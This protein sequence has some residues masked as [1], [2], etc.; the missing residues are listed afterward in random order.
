MTIKFKR[1]ILLLNPPAPR[2]YLR[3][4][5]C[6]KLSSGA[7]Y[8]QPSDLTV[9]SGVLNKSFYIYVI[10]AIAENKK[11]P[12]ILK[13]IARKKIKTIISLIGTAT[14]QEDLSTLKTLKEKHQ[15]FIAVSGDIVLGDTKEIFQKWPFIDAL[16]TDFTSCEINSFFKST[17]RS[18][19]RYFGINYRNNS[20]KLIIGPEKPN[21]GLISLPL[22]R[23]DL[24]PL[25]RYRLPFFDNQG[26]AT[27]SSSFGCPFNCD[28]C[29]LGTQTYR[30]RSPESIV[31]EIEMIFSLGI[32]QFIFRDPLFEANLK[33]AK[34]ICHGIISH[35]LK[36]NWSCNSRVDTILKDLNLLPLMKQAGC[37]MILF[38]VESGSEQVLKDVNKRI[39]IS[40]IKKAFSVCHNLQISTSGYFIIGLLKDTP[41]TVCKTIDFAIELDPDFAVFSY[42]SPDYRTKLR[43]QLANSKL[44]NLSLVNSFDRGGSKNNAISTKYLTSEEIIKWQ[45]NAFFKFYF[46]WDY[47]KKHFWQYLKPNRINIT[48]SEFYYLVKNYLIT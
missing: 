12:D 36:I 39:N 35:N 9:L 14:L 4:F 17:Q 19:K 25:K 13:I 48:F 7:Y 46:R 38:G 41:K 34:E 6:S 5:Y 24:F 43:Q 22:P 33:R 30:Y 26:V 28:F 10:D 20:G 29:V 16:I 8:W 2:K 18:T 31:E 21:V 40:Q 15:C 42:P 3:D 27:I 32:K 44:I 45:K 37:E 23:H 1:R 11:L 47:I